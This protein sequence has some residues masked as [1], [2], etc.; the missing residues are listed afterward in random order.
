MATTSASLRMGDVSVSRRVSDCSRN[1]CERTGS[2]S[3]WR[4]IVKWAAFQV[5][6]DAG[7]SFL[8]VVTPSLPSTRTNGELQNGLK[9]GHPLMSF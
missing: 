2:T 7:P 5:Q 4:R 6:H 1:Y 9:P 3:T 8:L